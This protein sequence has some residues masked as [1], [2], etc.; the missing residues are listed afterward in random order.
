M[1]LTILI[2]LTI[3]DHGQARE[4]EG[5]LCH[6]STRQHLQEDLSNLQDL[7]VAGGSLEDKLTRCVWLA[8]HATS[9]TLRQAYLDKCQE[10]VKRLEGSS[11]ESWGR[12]KGRR[13]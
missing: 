13:K 6:A 5:H 8:E 10:I 9:P 3:Q 7:E 1:W 2:D 12:S 4:E 11:R